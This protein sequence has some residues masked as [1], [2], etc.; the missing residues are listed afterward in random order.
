MRHPPLPGSSK[1]FIRTGHPLPLFL[2]LLLMLPIG[3]FQTLPIDRLTDIGAVLRHEQGQEVFIPAKYL[4]PEA[5]AGQPLRVFL[6]KDHEDRPIAT[7]LRPYLSLNQVGYLTVRQVSQVGAFLDWGLE[8]DLFVPFREQIGRMQ[9]GEQHL[10]Y[11]YLDERTDRLAASA[12]LNRFL[13]N[14]ELTVKE[15]DAVTLHIWEAT[16]LGYRTVINHR[17]VGLLYHNEL[18]QPVAPGQQ[19]TGYIKHIRSDQKIDLALQPQGYQAIEPNAEKILQLLRDGQGFLP[20][21]D[22]SS[23]ESISEQFQMSKKVFKKALGSL[24]KQRLVRL[25][26]D[27]IYLN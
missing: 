25:E 17:H 15:G 26:S 14:D 10:V 6:Y 13:D 12:Q 7:T 19:L 23:P 5:R 27:G 3:T 20:F 11:L 21:T 22:R 1:S 2:T 9:P 8:K 24:Y 4:P 18:F 16:D